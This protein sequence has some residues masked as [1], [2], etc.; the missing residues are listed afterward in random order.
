MIVRWIRETFDAIHRGYNNF[1]Y[2]ASSSDTV[3][4]TIVQG[5]TGR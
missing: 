4:P 2:R 3:G 1:V 5:L